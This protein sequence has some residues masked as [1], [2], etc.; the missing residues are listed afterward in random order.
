[1]PAETAEYVGLE[2]LAE[3]PGISGQF[4]G[5]RAVLA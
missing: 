2:G 5:G 4:F 1:M 3:G